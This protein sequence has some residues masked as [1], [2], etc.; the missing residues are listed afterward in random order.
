MMLLTKL[1]LAHLTGDFL[2]QPTSWV[3]A[4]ENK[5]LK[6]YQLY[7]HALLHGLII[8]LLVWDWTFLTWAALLAILHLVIDA[9][10]LLLQK[11]ETIRIYFFAD[12]LAHAISLYLIFCWYSG[13][14]PVNPG[15]FDQPNLQ[16]LTMIVFLTMPCSFIIK[17]FIA[18]WSPD[19]EQNG[20][21]SLEDAGKII[22]IFERL[23]VFIFVVTVH[24]DAVGFLL[25]A[26]S[27][28]RFGD[29]RESKDRKLTEYIL[30]G[31]LLSFGIA[32]LTGM[33]YTAMLPH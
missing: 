8:M 13:Y 6:A 3:R 16:L 15:F 1:I 14:T 26:K 31:T 18:K 12:Q 25:A 7:L 29:L 23:F 19:A 27:V 17:M 22:G 21:E 10:K 30:I 24:W 2:L 28:F 20:D 5:R 11:K 32:I 33:A 4:K 9:V